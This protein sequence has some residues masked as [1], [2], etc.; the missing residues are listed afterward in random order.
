MFMYN[1]TP[2]GAH[3]FHTNA[4]IELA[5]LLMVVEVGWSVTLRPQKP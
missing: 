1:L 2:S 3:L 5:I 4:V